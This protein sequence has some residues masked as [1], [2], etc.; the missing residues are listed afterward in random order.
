MPAACSGMYTI[1]VNSFSVPATGGYGL[2]FQR[3]TAP[4][5]ATT[6]YFG[7]ASFATLTTSA[8]IGTFQFTAAANS[9][10]QLRMT[11][12]NSALDPVIQIFSADGTRLCSA[13]SYGATAEIATCQLPFDG[14]YTVLAT[15]LGDGTG[16]YTLALTCLNGM[17]GAVTPPLTYVFLP[18]VR[19]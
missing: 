15:S 10:V 16:P 2:T 4:E 7:Y 17:C 8:S 18:L 14:A 12:P 9:S 13:Y 11:R 19:K 6:L 1:L 3:I 5:Q